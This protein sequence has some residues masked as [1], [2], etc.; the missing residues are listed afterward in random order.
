MM[1]KFLRDQRGQS[2]IVVALTITAVTALAATSVEV[3]H[4][5][6][7]YRQLV[8]ST[9][10]AALAGAQAMPN[11]VTATT[12]VT[13]YSAQ[14]G[15]KN[16]TPVLQ[17]AV[18]TPTF[19]CYSSVATSM[20]TPCETSTGAAGGYNAL[21]VTQTASVNLWFGGLIGMPKMNLAATATAAM[22]GGS[23]I[24]WNIA[25]I[26]D[27]TNSM[28]HPDSGTQCSG[29][30]ISC[31][32]KGVQALLGDL[33]P[34]GLG[35]TCG[36]NT[37]PV[38]SVALYVFPP[39]LTT[40]AGKDYCS[41]GSGNPTHEYYM[42]PTLNPLWTYQI[43]PFSADYRTSDAA[44][45]LSS[46]SNIVKAAGGVSGCSGIQAPGGAGTYYAQVINTAQADLVTQQ[47]AIPGSQNAMIILSDGDATAT[48][49]GGSGSDLQSSLAGLLNGILGTNPNSYTYPSAVG[50]CGQAV[51]AAKAAATAGTAVYT[52]GYG[53]P[54]SGCSSDATN[55]ASVTTKGGSW[56][57][58]DSPCQALAA[59][60][61]AQLNFYSDDGN[62]CLATATAN[63][64]ITSLTAI[65]HAITAGLTE[66][67]LIPNGTT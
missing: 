3:G 51:V 49:S 1:R 20:N 52:I 46:S 34:C 57:P 40:T 10:A 62:G 48:Y 28:S 42:V 2:V 19:H 29:T 38:D 54:T 37:S 14:T 18:A 47:K 58:G 30:Q 31:A 9:N 61:S 45:A 6:Y 16:A 25:I 23:N 12:N 64:S 26:L 21:S 36:S 56:G 41:G 65:F 66:P 67:R 22:R 35:A 5:Y 27:T 24:P 7:A 33:D 13:A 44:S 8:S 11:T 59:M 4:V 32:L 55:S 17:G 43:I 15:Q 50:E 63:Q 39:V 60:A 53:S